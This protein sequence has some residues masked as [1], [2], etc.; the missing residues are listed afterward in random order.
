VPWFRISFAE[1]AFRRIL[2]AHGW[3]LETLT[4]DHGVEA[5]VD[6]YTQHRAQHTSLPDG[7]DVLVFRWKPRE[8]Q[9]TR[10]LVR[11]GDAANPVCELT[12]AFSSTMPLPRA[13][14][15]RHLDP[16]AEIAVPSFF[17]GEAVSATLRYEKV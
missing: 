15:V 7:G 2:K 13:G 11:S 12:L 3:D 9:I 1:N 10:R 6:F 8:L 17:T 16:T 14:Q 5:M 4:I